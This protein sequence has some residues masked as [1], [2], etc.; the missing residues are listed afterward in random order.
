MQ[1]ILNQVCKAVQKY[2]LIAFK[3]KI[4]IGLSGGKDSLVLLYIL[5][6]YRDYI[7]NSISLTAVTIDMGFGNFEELLNLKLICSQLE[8]DFK[9]ER[10]D[11]AKIVFDIRKEKNPCSLCAKMRRG[12]L[13]D[14]AK[15]QGCNKIALGHHL[16]DVIET[17][18]LNLFNEG[19]MA[20]FTPKAY[21]SRK[22]LYLIR[23]LVYVQERDIKRAIARMQFNV[24][25]NPCPNDKISAR[26]KMKT[27]LADLEKTNK[28]VK[29]RIFGA[30]CRANIS[31]FQV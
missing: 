29:N 6:K 15:S 14:A 27:Y 8:V 12:A 11:I 25:Q 22:D 7:D 9:I 4:A 2:N 18:M 10:T 28:G 24:L 21:L 19:R 31:G 20:T 1:R 13:H 23:P 5:A 3:D 30:I 16:D 17:Y 26:A